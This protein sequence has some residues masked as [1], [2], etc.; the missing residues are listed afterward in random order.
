MLFN[1]AGIF[2]KPLS[3]G[4]LGRAQIAHSLRRVK[5]DLST[6]LSTENIDPGFSSLPANHMKNIKPNFG[7]P[8]T[9]TEE[10]NVCHQWISVAAYYKAQDSEFVPGLELDDWLAVGID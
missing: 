5:F 4:I 9:Q 1:N 10:S 2:I 8:V 7:E 6:I 3:Q